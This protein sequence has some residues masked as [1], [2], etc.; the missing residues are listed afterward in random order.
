MNRLDKRNVTPLNIIEK[1]LNFYNSRL[2]LR[3]LA[4]I[5]YI[6]LYYKNVSSEFVY[7]KF[8]H[9]SDLYIYFVSNVIS[10]YFIFYY[11]SPKFFFTEKYRQFFLFFGLWYFI[12]F[13][14]STYLFI[15]EAFTLNDFKYNSAGGLYNNPYWLFI[16]SFKKDGLLGH[17]KSISYAYSI[18]LE[19]RNQFGIILLVK[20]L[21]YFFENTIKQKHLNELNYTLE[22]QFLKSQLNPHFLF[23]SLNNIY[24]LIMSRKPETE[25]AIGQL[26]S[27]LKQSFG[28]MSGDKVRLQAEVEYLKNYINL[29]KIRHDQHVKIDFE[30]DE[31]SLGNHFIAPRVL[32]PFVENA[33]KHGLYNN[34]NYAMIQLSLTVK[35]GQLT[36]NVRN[37]KPKMQVKK[38][39]V[40]GIG[41]VNIKRRLSLLYPAHSLQIQDHSD[42]YEI[43]LSLFL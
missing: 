4:H 1:T 42:R 28:D 20:S 38:P 16:Q 35:E 26:Q 21:K 9:E 17:F 34:L 3:I 25:E 10:T 7:E 30:M 11:L 14:Y 23:N 6:F 27:L 36:F 15:S 13:S 22:A 43:N 37:T 12:P 29:E 2:W 40:G 19:F 39:T 31:N 18:I 5:A 41:L 8:K 33:F 32:L 24:G